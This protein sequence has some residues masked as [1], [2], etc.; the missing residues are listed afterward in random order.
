MVAWPLLGKGGGNRR[1]A[2]LPQQEGQPLMG[3]ANKPL[4]EP[5]T[6]KS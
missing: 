4:W 1:R 6:A 5:Q 2:V 3:L